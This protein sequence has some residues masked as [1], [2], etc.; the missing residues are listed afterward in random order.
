[1]S[2]IKI[3]ISMDEDTRQAT[4]AKWVKQP[5]EKGFYVRWKKG[6]GMTEL[7]Y[8]DDCAFDFL[9]DDAWF[10]GPFSIPAR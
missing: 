2:K 4:F 10:F 6:E 5:K 7:F 3:E 1:M 9:S 8:D